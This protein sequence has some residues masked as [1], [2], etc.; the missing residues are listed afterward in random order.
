MNYRSVED[1]NQVI[2]RNLD[3]IQPDIDLVVGI[4]RSGLL[5]AT[6]LSLYLNRPLADLYGLSEGRLLAKGKRSVH[7]YSETTVRNARRILIVDDCVSQGTELR[8]AREYIARLRL[9]DR[10]V[11]LTVFSFSENSSL[12]DI[13][14]Q[15]IPRP[16]CFQWSYLHTPELRNYCLDIDGVL[17]RDP[18]RVQ[19]DNGA[20]YEE[21]LRDAIPLFRPTARVGHLIT[22][23]LEKYRKPTEEWLSRNN[24]RYDKLVMLDVPD[25]ATR[26]RPGVVARFKSEAYLRSGAILFIESSSGLAAKIAELSGRP[27]MCMTTNR[28]IGNPV[29]DS[30]LVHIQK[31][32]HFGRRLRRVPKKLLGL[33]NRVGAKAGSASSGLSRF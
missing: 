28:V 19:D 31:L 9:S 30:Y 32:Q 14:L 33:V 3:R 7:G 17:C 13:T 11:F 24:I 22:A 20:K 29:A 23:R 16:M 21:F 26:K 4:P 2:L 15:V 5:A 10:A 1:M 18:S 25:P 6:L 8:K 27:V 12:A